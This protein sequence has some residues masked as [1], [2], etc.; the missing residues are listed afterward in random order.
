MTQQLYIN[1]IIGGLFGMLF[2]IFAIKL[3]AVRS[4]AKAANLPFSVKDYFKDDWLAITASF[5]CVLILVWV[6]DEI[7]GYNPSFLR[8]TKFFFVFVGY[9]GSS[10]LVGMLGKFDKQVQN[11]VDIKTNQLDA[12]KSESHADKL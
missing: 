3:P 8:Y 4:R 11:I 10:I 12:I 5:L 9:T 7:I 2:H 6:L 1:C